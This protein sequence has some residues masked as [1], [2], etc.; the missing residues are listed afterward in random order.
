MPG[1]QASERLVAVVRH[2]LAEAGWRLADLAAIAVVT[3]PGSFTGVRVGLS[4]AKGLG[5]AAG[6]PLIAISRLATLAA[7]AE[8]H[9]GTVCA[10]LDAGRGEFYCGNFRDQQAAGES[11][12]AHDAA[13]AAAL[14]ADLALCCEETVANVLLPE[15]AVRLVQEPAA[16]DA[17]P[18]AVK[19]LAA[20]AFDDPVTLDANYLRRTDAEIFA[21]TPV[22][23]TA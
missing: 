21:K 10:L 18:L 8:S 11:L 14:R 13:I 4:V 19:R 5:E 9:A 12:L 3:G 23:R 2:S 1:R 15:V 7:T 17:L 16:S 20:R 6:V 22:Q